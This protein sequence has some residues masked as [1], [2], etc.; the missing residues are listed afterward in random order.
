MALTD[1]HLKAESFGAESVALGVSNS[2]NLGARQTVMT[3][4]ETINSA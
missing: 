1:A 3:F 2:W 4:P